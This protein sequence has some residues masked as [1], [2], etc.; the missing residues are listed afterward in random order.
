M[1]GWH[2]PDDCSSRRAVIKALGLGTVGAGLGDGLPRWL[3]AQ[4]N[5]PGPARSVTRAVEPFEL[6]DVRL[7]DGPFRE[8]QQRDGAYMLSLDPDRLLH[9]FRVNAGL[10]PKAPVYGGWESQQPWVSIR[11]HGHTLGHWLTAGSLMY[12]STGDE[13]FE[14]RVHYIVDELKACQ[15]AG[16][17][18]LV[19]AFPDGDETLRNAV[20]GERYQGVPWYTM[21]KIFAGLRDAH[22]LAGNHLAL[23]VLVRL[24]G[25]A[26]LS[27]SPMSD[28]EFQRMLDREHGGM[29]EVLADVHSLTDDGSTLE[30]AR[31][32]CHQ[33]LLDPLARGEDPLDGLHGNTQIPKVAGFM[34]LYEL[35]GEPVYLT[36]S[37]FFWDRVVNH[38][39]YVTGG[40]GDGEHFFPPAEFPAH[41]DSAK[42]NETC[43]SYNMLRLTRMLYMHDPAVRYGDFYERALYNTILA[44]QD[45][46]SGWNTYFQATRPGY[47]KLY[48]TPEDSFWCCTGTGMENHAKY[49]DSIYFHGP[50]TLYV[51]LFIPSELTWAE[52]GLRIRQTT[53][54]PDDNVTRLEIEA[55]SPVR[56]TLRLRYPSWSREAA[57][58][59]NGERFETNAAPG[60]HIAVERE[61]GSG[62]TV[63]LRLPMS[64]RGVELPGDPNRVALMYGPLVLAG[65]LGTEGLYPGADILRNERTSGEILN[66]PVEVPELS[67]APGDVAGRV[68]R[69]DDGDTLRFETRDTG[70]PRDVTLI[71][72]HRLHHERYNLYWRVREG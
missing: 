53:R 71:P 18:G 27:T 17:T 4:S 55:S 47:L 38:R 66:T 13:R 14:A 51:N 65:Q 43:G 72:Y 8:A 26:S 7:L 25:W 56:A 36:A 29:S 64:V 34:R 23:D 57:V 69:V 46:D 58:A 22:V 3:A 32:F 15:D 68:R 24:T 9:N 30:L 40:H 16:G 62:D 44:S 45:P 60:G 50:E 5:A 49:G 28:A 52:K 48:H 67:G 39:S 10:E 1:S 33:A 63:E 41:L 35:T 2:G 70:N 42:T 20:A 11:C 59:I 12:A 31:R 61:W 6:R 54:F 21:H 19:C 37:R